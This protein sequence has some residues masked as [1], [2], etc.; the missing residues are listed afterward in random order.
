VLAACCG[1]PGHEAIGTDEDGAASRDSVGGGKSTGRIDNCGRAVG[2]SDGGVHTMDVDRDS[3]SFRR[4]K[5][6]AAPSVGCMAREQREVA[7]EEIERG[8]FAAVALE[9][10]ERV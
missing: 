9:A 7:A 1:A 4:A 3:Q 6:A 10:W 5:G 8:D 2:I